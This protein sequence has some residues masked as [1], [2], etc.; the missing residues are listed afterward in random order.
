MKVEIVRDVKV[1]E[2]VDIEFPYYYHHWT[3]HGSYYGKITEDQHIQIYIVKGK[4]WM[5]NRLDCTIR[6]DNEVFNTLSSYYTNEYE[7]KESVFLA[8][9]EILMTAA[10]ST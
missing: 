5:S 1:K 9:K 3:E 10:T 7:S 4:G 8:A 6:I 2:I